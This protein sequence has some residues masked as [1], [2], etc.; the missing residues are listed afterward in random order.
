MQRLTA[1]LLFIVRW[2]DL[3]IAAYRNTPATESFALSLS[4]LGLEHI[5]SLRFYNI[6]TGVIIVTS[7]SQLF[8]IKPCRI[9]NGYKTMHTTDHSRSIQHRINALWAVQHADSINLPSSPWLKM[10]KPACTYPVIYF[11]YWI[12]A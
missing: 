11:N 7:E 3:R 5:G 8:I 6:N 9:V 12:S 2:K 10:S 4:I 1:L